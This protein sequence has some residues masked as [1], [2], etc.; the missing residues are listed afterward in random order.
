M[1]VCVNV[2]IAKKNLVENI[3]PILVALKGRLEASHS[4]LLRHVI[5]FLR[6]VVRDFKDEVAG[7]CHGAASSRP[8]VMCPWSVLPRP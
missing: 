3:M 7:A 4:P 8:C 1:R 6:D 5:A 2:Q